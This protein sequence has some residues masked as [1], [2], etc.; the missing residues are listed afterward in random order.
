MI[1]GA[2]KSSAGSSSNDLQQ[3]SQP[4]D[5]KAL[6]RSGADL[7]FCEDGTG[8]HAVEIVIPLNGTYWTHV[9]V[10][11]KSNK[12]VKSMKFRSGKYAC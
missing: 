4:N 6:A 9:L 3:C 7:Y 11:D 12:R 2:H 1:Y 8:Q 10:Y 5:E